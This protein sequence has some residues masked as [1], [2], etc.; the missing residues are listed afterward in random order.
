V[1]KGEL[2]AGVEDLRT[3]AW[4]ATVDGWG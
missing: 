3:G 1:A 4:D 2:T